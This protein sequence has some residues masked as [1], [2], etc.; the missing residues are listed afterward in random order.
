M[1]T[2]LLIESDKI[3]A[4]NIESG[5]KKLQLKVDWQVDPQSAMDNADK[6]APDIIVLDLLLAG[7]SGVEFLYEFRSYPEWED[8]PIIL[9]SSISAEELS[10]SAP[11]FGH[12][13]IQDFLYKPNTPLYELMRVVRKSLNALNLA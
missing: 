11:G 10:E 2:V 1:K 3:L 5:F 9:Y 6:K 7:R 12:L 13:N 4:G 8:T